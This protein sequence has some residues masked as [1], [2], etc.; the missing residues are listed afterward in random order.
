MP[1]TTTTTAT[2]RRNLLVILLS[3]NGVPIEIECHPCHSKQTNKQRSMKSKRNFIIFTNNH[4]LMH[5]C[6]THIQSH[7][8]HTHDGNVCVSV[9]ICVSSIQ[10]FSEISFDIH[11]HL[12][13]LAISF[14]FSDVYG[15]I[16]SVFNIKQQR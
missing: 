10:L 15:K 11:A 3:T 5:A 9:C 2:S 6:S 16:Y 7:M 4:S 1:F 8:K 14:P 13:N 12:L